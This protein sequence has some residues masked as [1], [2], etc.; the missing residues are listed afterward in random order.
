MANRPNSFA[1][2]SFGL[3]LRMGLSAFRIVIISAFIAFTA[4][5]PAQSEFSA[6]LF[7]SLPVGEYGSNGLA[8][9]GFANPGMGVYVHSQSDIGWLPYGFQLEFRFSFQR[10]TINTGAIEK[11]F[12]P[13]FQSQ[14]GLQTN[15]FVS[16]GA[17]RPV[18]L[19]F[20][21][22]YRWKFSPDWS[23]RIGA[24]VGVIFAN[25]DEVVFAITDPAGTALAVETINN[26]S[27]PLFSWYAGLRLER[28]FSDSWSA[29]IF[30]D[31]NGGS[32]NLEAEFDL[33]DGF[34]TTRPVHFVNTGLFLVYHLGE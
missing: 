32:S 20:G 5:L 13:Y 12:N 8:E 14:L 29:G 24:G 30:G 34:K 21:P 10:H 33:P 6:G 2:I 31:F 9:G 15:T 11:T 18:Q 23:A 26:G 17:Y 27:E 25:M 22:H 19:S 1:K 16:A 7:A 28:Q 3:C 4:D